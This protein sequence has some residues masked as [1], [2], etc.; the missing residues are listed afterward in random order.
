MDITTV[1]MG[2]ARRQ[3]QKTRM[4]KEKLPRITDQNIQPHRQNDMH[5]DE[6]LKRIIGRTALAS[7]SELWRRGG[8]IIKENATAR[9]AI[10][11]MGSN[12]L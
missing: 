3:W 1:M 10:A 2:A 6:D 11:M 4:A 8:L 5:Q 12:F 9:R 7:I